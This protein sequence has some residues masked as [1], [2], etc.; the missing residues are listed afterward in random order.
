MLLNFI[1]WTTM[2]E[3]YRSLRSLNK[4]KFHVEGQQTEIMNSL[5][6]IFTKTKQIRY[7]ICHY[8]EVLGHD[9]LDTSLNV[10]VVKMKRINFKRPSS[11]H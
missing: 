7:L 6:R 10:E 2:G 3:Q 9:N 4:T 11:M 1:T 5:L 8:Y